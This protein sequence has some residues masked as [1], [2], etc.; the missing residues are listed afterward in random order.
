MFI[1][2]LC[3]CVKQFG[4][5]TCLC[6]WTRIQNTPVCTMH[7]QNDE[8]DIDSLFYSAI[9]LTYLSRAISLKLVLEFINPTLR[10]FSISP[11]IV[12]VLSVGQQLH[13]ENTN[14]FFRSV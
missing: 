5:F 12:K 3:I 11:L 6:I 4:P 7:L 8:I 2:I 1:R 9:S 14:T 13:F 10:S